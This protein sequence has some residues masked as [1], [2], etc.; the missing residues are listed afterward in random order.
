[1]SDLSSCRTC[2]T[3]LWSEAEQS[4]KPSTW[5]ISDRRLGIAIFYP[6]LMLDWELY[7]L[8][9][10]MTRSNRWSPETF[11]WSLLIHRD[12]SWLQIKHH[13]SNKGDRIQR[14]ALYK[15]ILLERI[16]YLVNRRAMWANHFLFHALVIQTWEW[17]WEMSDLYK[18][19]SAYECR[20]ILFKN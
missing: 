20:F 8:Q 15:L 6:L 14:S 12:T 5:W 4:T 1:M 9:Q 19:L 17:N 2:R 11:R 7:N 3:E 18:Q 10:P 16:S 13:I